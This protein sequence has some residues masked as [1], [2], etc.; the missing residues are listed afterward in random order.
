MT[1]KKLNRKIFH[2]LKNTEANV[3]TEI[4][5]LSRIIDIVVLKEDG[6]YSYELKL[7]NWKKAI[8]Q[9]KDQ[10]IGSNYSILCMPNENMSYN[11][12]QKII[13]EL[14]FYGF[15]FELWD[16]KN[17]KLIKVLK[18]KPNKLINRTL[19]KKLETNLNQF[20]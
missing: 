8:E 16:Q 7:Q 9:L 2:Y 17:H 5:F 6:I 15:G 11:V 1:E 19:S 3:F 18:P 20:Q 4:P 14:S 10:R 12:Q 13:S